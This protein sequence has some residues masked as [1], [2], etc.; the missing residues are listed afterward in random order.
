MLTANFVPALP[1]PTERL[2]LSQPCTAALERTHSKQ[3]N[4]LFL[5]YGKLY[6][7]RSVIVGQHDV[8][9]DFRGQI[10]GDIVL[11]LRP[12]Q[13]ESA[14]MSNEVDWRPGFIF[15]SS[16]WGCIDQHAHLAVTCRNQ[17]ILW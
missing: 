6:L 12:S 15:R 16:R 10:A 2:P 4:E 13:D 11:L 9:P 7:G 17:D 5:S 14:T 1:P 8:A 3:S